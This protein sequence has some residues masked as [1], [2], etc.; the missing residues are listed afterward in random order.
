MDVGSLQSAQPLPPVASPGPGAAL[1]APGT[2]AP[3]PQAEPER[4]LEAEWP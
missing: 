1:L 4:E 3:A 2:A